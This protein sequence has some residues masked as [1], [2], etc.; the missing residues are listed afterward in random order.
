MAPPLPCFVNIYKIPSQTNEPNIRKTCY[1]KNFQRETEETPAV[2]FK[3]KNMK[4]QYV[5]AS[6]SL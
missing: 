1:E 5:L 4:L 2:V 6:I 3:E